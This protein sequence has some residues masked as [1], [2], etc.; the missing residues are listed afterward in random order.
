MLFTLFEI[1]KGFTTVIFK[2]KIGKQ[3]RIQT[4]AQS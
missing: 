3:G 2:V 4:V 1:L